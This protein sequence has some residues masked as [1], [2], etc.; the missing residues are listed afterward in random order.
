MKM[1][2]LGMGFF[3]GTFDCKRCHPSVRNISLMLALKY[4]LHNNLPKGDSYVR[5]NWTWCNR[6]NSA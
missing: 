5:N 2:I 1:P 6:G 3:I 4:L